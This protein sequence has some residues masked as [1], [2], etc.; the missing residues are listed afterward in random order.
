MSEILE[1]RLNECDLKVSDILKSIIDLDS[2]SAVFIYTSHLEGLGTNDSDFDIYVLDDKQR[3]SGFQ[4]TYKN[5]KVQ[6]AILNG[7]MLDI[8]Y[9]HNND[10]QRLINNIND[11]KNQGFDIEELKLLHRLKTG[12]V[13]NGFELATMIKTFINKSKLQEK[14]MLF[15]ITFAKSE[16]V[17]AI[18]MYNA[19]ELLCAW[20]CVRIS[21]DY[22]IGALNAKHGNTN[23]KMKWIPKIFEFNHGY[24]NILYNKFYELYVYSDINEEN[25][26]LKTEELIEFVQ[27]ILIKVEI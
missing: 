23:L 11:S 15:Y 3:D 7:K 8:E 2:Q 18:S 14:I 5:S 6:I 1:R 24:E 25:L 4:R 26:S 10:I 27:D 19:G 16:L 20:R 9:W 21:L 12:V 22:A 13:V 17:D